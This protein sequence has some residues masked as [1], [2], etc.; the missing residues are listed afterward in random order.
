MTARGALTRS[1]RRTTRGPPSTSAFAWTDQRAERRR[2]RSA[3]SAGT[4]LR[5]LP[6]G[7]EGHVDARVSRGRSVLITGAAGHITG[8][9]TG[10]ALATRPGAG[11]WAGGKRDLWIRMRPGQVIGRTL[12]IR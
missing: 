2:A 9:S 7:I 4:S 3:R 6:P 5:V 12:H 11:P 10:E 1:R 8:P